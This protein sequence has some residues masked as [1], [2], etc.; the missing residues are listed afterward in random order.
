MTKKSSSKPLI[1]L[2]L[3]ILAGLGYAFYNYLAPHY[4]E[5][6]VEAVDESKGKPDL[7]FYAAGLFTLRQFAIDE[8]AK[9]VCPDL[10]SEA[11]LAAE[12][13]KYALRFNKPEASEKYGNK[14]MQ[15]YRECESKAKEAKGK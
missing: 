10:L 2:S 1:F 4:A 11:D 14:A 12:K 7:A 15:L 13:S 6:E 8:G 5:E 9:E 3:L